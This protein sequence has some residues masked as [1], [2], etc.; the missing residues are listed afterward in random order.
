MPPEDLR[1]SPEHFW[2]EF[3]KD[4]TVRVGITD[5]YGAQLQKIVFVELPEVGAALKKAERFGSIETAKTIEDMLS[6]VSGK[7]AAV[8]Q[9][10]ATR[11]ELIT[12]EPYGGGWMAV[13]ELTE[14]SELSTLLSAGEYEAILK[15]R[16]Q[17]AT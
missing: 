14:P 5:C 12:E 9:R 11:P 8:N 3:E 17:N 4:S 2:L 10:L 13:I 16:S 6:P 1:Y 7:V 15:E